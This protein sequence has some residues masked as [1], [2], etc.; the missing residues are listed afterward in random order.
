MQHYATGVYCHPWN[1]SPRSFG[2]PGAF[3]L[4]PPLLLRSLCQANDSLSCVSPIRQG[5]NYRLYAVMG[6]TAGMH[7]GEHI[8][9]FM[10]FHLFS[11]SLLKVFVSDPLLR[12]LPSWA[13][14]NRL[15]N[16]SVFKVQVEIVNGL[17]CLGVLF[18]LLPVAP[19]WPMTNWVALH[20]ATTG[21]DTAVHDFPRP[22]CFAVEL[23]PYAA[24]PPDPSSSHARWVHSSSQI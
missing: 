12:F 21:H 17:V 3:T 14:L 11:T 9:Q 2:V 4:S 18:G 19:R 24:W 6:S 10:F 5:S 23:N 8:Y 1:F 16:Y 20:G 7:V 15:T 13:V 22:G